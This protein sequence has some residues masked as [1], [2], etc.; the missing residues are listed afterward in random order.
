MTK[1]SVYNGLFS[2]FFLPIFLF[3]I[4]MVFW[5]FTED[6]INKIRVQSELTTLELF[7]PS[8][9]S[10]GQAFLRNWYQIVNETSYTLSKAIIGFMIG[11]A[12]ASI[13]ATSYVLFP[14]LRTL[15]FPA[16][17]AVNS[18]P[19]IGLA[20]VIVLLFG[21]G[22]FLSIA[23][24]SCIVS[25][26]PILLTL[27]TAFRTV[28]D[29]YLELAHLYNA[30]RLQT[31]LLIKLPLVAPSFFMALKLSF[32]A[33]IVGATIGEWMGSPHGVGQLITIALYQLNP[34]L[35]YACLIEIALICVLTVSIINLI[36]RLCLPWN[37]LKTRI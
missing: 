22:S 1:K 6:T 34:G 8:P 32:P 13:M 14:F 19:V 10:I 29:E 25:Y 7:I 11:T 18:F 23:I 28:S 20:P 4:V 26:F 37:F 9:I 24:I 16:V 30:T 12:I 5:Q 21:Q 3:C 35:L 33:S 36:E 2:K 27:D 17:F 15:T 31:I